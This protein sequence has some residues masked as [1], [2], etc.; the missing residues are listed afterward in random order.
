[1]RTSR[2]NIMRKLHGY[3]KNSFG[4]DNPHPLL[5][6][7]AITH[8]DV[9]SMSELSIENLQEMYTLLEEHKV[10]WNKIEQ[11][12]LTRIPE[13]G[14]KQ[15]YLVK[16]CQKE[17]GWSDDYLQEL[18][19]KRYGFVDWIYLTGREAFAFCRYLI[20]RSRQKRGKAE[21][22]SKGKSKKGKV[23]E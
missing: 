13:M 15:Q 8:F 20:Q 7:L 3:A 16:R 6:Q 9:K 18:A 21:Y 4:L 23:D 19:M 17:L 10:D 5:H 11:L 1:M 12:G 22:K 14:Q 2:A